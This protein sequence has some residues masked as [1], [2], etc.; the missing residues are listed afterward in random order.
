MEP[1]DGALAVDRREYAWLTTAL[2]ASRQDIGS[3]LHLPDE[4]PRTE[5]HGSYYLDDT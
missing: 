1:A 2:G 4:A 3:V 5:D